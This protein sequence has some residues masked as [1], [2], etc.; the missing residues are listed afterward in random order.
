MIG[1]DVLDVVA[2]AP[3]TVRVLDNGLTVVVRELRRSPVAALVTHVSAG[4]LDED[5]REVGIAHVLEHMYFKGTRRFGPG[6]IARETKAAG[7]ILNAS[8][9]YD[10]T[11]YY[12]LLPSESLERGIELQAD[13]LRDSV[14]DADELERELRVIIE[15]ARRKRDTPAAVARETMHATMFDAHRL[16]RW[17]IGLEDQLAGY[18]REDV[19]S[20]YRTR[21]RP[22]RIVVSIAGD[23]ATDRVLELAEREYGGLTG[24]DAEPSIGPPEP[25]RREFRFRALPGDLSRAY[26]AWGWRGVARTDA[27]RPF[28][29]Q[30]AMVIGDGRA[31]RLFQEV[32]EAGHALAV[33]AGH[34]ATRDTG[35]FT[36][37]AQ[38]RTEDV[39]RALRATAD[40]LRRLASDGVREAE[41]D[42]GK[43]MLAARTLRAFETAQGQANVLADWQVL[44]DWRLV[45]DDLRAAFGADAA[46]LDALAREF[47]DPGAATLLVH[48]PDGTLVETEP[49]HVAERL[50][51]GTVPD[52]GPLPQAPAIVAAEGTARFEREE[53]GVRF[54]RAEGAR[55]AIEELRGS[56]LVTLCIA[57]EGGVV[58]ETA[59][60][61]GATSLVMRLST[62]GSERLS[63]SDIALSS[64]ILGSSMAAAA[65]ADGF[66]WSMTVPAREAG[67]AIRLL[68]EVAFAPAFPQGAVE[69]ERAM[70]LEDVLQIRD[71]MRRYPLLLMA[72]AAWE[73]HPYGF[74]IEDFE[75]SLPAATRAALRQW[76]THR[77]SAGPVWFIAAGD[78]DAGELAGLIAG[79]AGPGGGED[80]PGRPAPSWPL[81]PAESAAERDRAQTALAI[82]LPGPDRRA[83][84]YPPLMVGGAAVSGLGGRAFEELRSRRSLAYTVSLGPQARG[85]AGSFVGYIATSPDREAEAR[86]A[87][88]AEML[89]LA[90]EGVDETELELARR[91]LLGAREIRRQTTGQHAADL[92]DALVTG[93]GLVEI[94][95]FRDRILAVTPE[96]VRDAAARWFDAGR[97]VTG[98]VRGRAS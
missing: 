88:L 9:S 78:V 90:G 91:Y 45:L 10:Q 38:A 21:Y 19:L 93:R 29:D 28:V 61:A 83:D 84:D 34:L 65:G 55:I 98:I 70:A 16:R 82:G 50:F 3:T 12:V 66:Q 1:A 77:I 51:G 72:S 68:A 23:V 4:Y 54:Y 63:A 14:I 26:I 56:G 76:H 30:L 73:G 11:R 96:G 37:S 20:F 64:E 97:A 69:R 85:A 7:G 79:S 5:D 22:D 18:R 87:L 62:R 24:E 41:L 75:A 40:S 8:T 71:D 33:G 89:R 27:R 15:E 47:L 35:V 44:G 2:N 92:V 43:R 17:R 80:P 60:R 13:A 49:E 32:R 52:S 48:A 59:D 67:R 81:Q 74:R 46:T 31:S 95:E 36:V 25:A 57:V 94:R 6:E 53:D 58:D 39:E 86:D 42:R